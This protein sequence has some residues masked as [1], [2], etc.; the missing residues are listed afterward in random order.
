M[1]KAAL[2]YAYVSKETYYRAKRDLLHDKRDLLLYLAYLR[3]AYVSE[4]TYT[5][6]KRD[7]LYG[8]RDL[9]LH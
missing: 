5:Y 6:G 9:L 4:E 3:H 1:S 7:L 2:R 8:K